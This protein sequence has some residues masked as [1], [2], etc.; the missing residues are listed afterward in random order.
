MAI[1]TCVLIPSYNEA[2]TI[3]GIVKKL[4]EMRIDVIVVDDGSGDDTQARASENGALVIRHTKNTG[5]G[6]SLKKGFEFI[7]RSTDFGAVIIMD[8]DGQ[9]NPD[10][11]KKFI[12]RLE[13][14]GDDI[15]VGNRMPQTKGMPLIRLATNKAMS[16]LLSIICKQRIPDTQCGFKLIRR[17]ILEKI[18]LDCESY[19]FD[20]EVLIKASRKHYKIASVPIETIYRGETSYINPLIDTIRFIRLLLKTR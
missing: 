18:T 16:T 12:T 17:E 14:S 19:D 20:S 6:A 11:I 9:H 8:G 13:G 10:D 5:K 7:L 1:K 4:K 15:I 2:G 3:G